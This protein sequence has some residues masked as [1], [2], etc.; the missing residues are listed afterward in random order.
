MN[1]DIP[2]P[3]LETVEGR[4][5][6]RAERILRDINLTYNDLKGKRVLDCAAGEALVETSARKQ[7]IDSVISLDINEKGLKQFRNLNE[8]STR[9]TADHIQMPFADKSMDLIIVH[10][11]NAF[12]ASEEEFKKNIQESMRV[13][14]DDGEIRIWP[15][16]LVSIGNEIRRNQNDTTKEAYLRVNPI[17]M[18]QAMEESLKLVQKLGYNLTVVENNSKPDDSNDPDEREAFEVNPQ[19]KYF[20]SIKK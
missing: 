4:V 20:W 7:G 3:N 2:R 8:S 11:A 5:E 16:M 9:V 17:S 19:W 1:F 12:S 6:H 10:G 13:L 18:R 14:T 15:P